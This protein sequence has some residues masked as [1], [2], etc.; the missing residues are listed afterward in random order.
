MARRRALR[1]VRGSIDGGR[2]SAGEAR[3]GEASSTFAAVLEPVTAFCVAERPAEE[4]RPLGIE[5]VVVLDG[6]LAN[7]DVERESAELGREDDDGPWDELRD[8]VPGALAAEGP[9]TR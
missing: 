4:R 2:A 5:E 3:A 6:R 9:L 8:R 7:D 1:F